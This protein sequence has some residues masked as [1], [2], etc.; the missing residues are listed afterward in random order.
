MADMF[1]KPGNEEG[2]LRLLG[3]MGGLFVAGELS[4][5]STENMVISGGRPLGI[6]LGNPARSWQRIKSGEAFPAVRGIGKVVDHLAGT[7]DTSIGD[8]LTTMAVTR[9]GKK[10]YDT[11]TEIAA[12]GKAGNA[13]GQHVSHNVKGA[14]MPHT[15]Y[16]DIANLL[17][18]K[19]VRQQDLQD[20]YNA[21]QTQNAREVRGQEQNT[22]ALKARANTAMDRGNLD[23][24][25]A[26]MQEMSAPQRKAF[27]SNRNKTR[28]ER[29]LQGK[30]RA[31]RARIMAEWGQKFSTLELR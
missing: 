20:T 13:F 16:E 7:S 6:D 2:K 15:G 5:L 25:A 4:G 27:L 23:D 3:G 17:G 12:Q 26:A 21:F 31:D 19:S 24:A 9:Y 22:Q 29:I 8:D 14:A 11:G 10:L 1:T 30:S 28:F 18:V